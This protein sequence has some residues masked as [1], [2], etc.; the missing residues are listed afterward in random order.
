GPTRAWRS[1]WPW[2]RRTPPWSC[3]CSPA[4]STAR[5]SSRTPRSA[6]GS[7][8]RRSRCCAGRCRAGGRGPAPGR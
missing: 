6:G 1:P 4:R 2:R 7:A 8:P 3:T 5:R